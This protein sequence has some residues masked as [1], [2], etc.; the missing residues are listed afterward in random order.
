MT[1]RVAVADNDIAFACEADETILEAAERAGFTLPYSCR[2]GLC[3]T[4]FG[5]LVA[6]DALIRGKGAVSGPR[7]DA[8]FCQ[9]RPRSDLMIRPARIQQGG[10][11]PRRTLDARIFRMRRLAPDVWHL[12][13]RFANGVRAGFVAG[14][15]LRVFL[16][17]G[18]SRNFSMANPPRDNDGVELHVREVPGGRFSQEM[19]SRLT[20]GDHLKV[21]MPYGTFGL[22]RASDAPANLLASGTG[23]APFVS[24]IKDQIARGETRP[25]HLYWGARTERDLYLDAL[26]RRWAAAYPWFSYTP[27][28]SEPDVDWA[29]RRGLVHAAVLADHPDLSGHDVY[30]CGNPLMVSAAQADF[31]DAGLPGARF[32]KDAFVPSGEVAA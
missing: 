10:P 31:A 27:V 9:T 7:A 32:H 28:L 6:G 8:V 22:D 24:I 14:Q 17:D 21:E 18:D 20:A 13:L 15:Y 23:F 11:P 16:D 2:K 30:A 5:D 12:H 4:C 25:L 1:F 3:S 29:G 26:P 19:L